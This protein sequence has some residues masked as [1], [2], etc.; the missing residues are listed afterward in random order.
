MA[1]ARK[2][3]EYQ[4]KQR[5][6]KCRNAPD[7]LR[8]AAGGVITAEVAAHTLHILAGQGISGP[9]SRGRSDWDAVLAGVVPA[10]TKMSVRQFTKAVLAA[11]KLGLDASWYIFLFNQYVVASSWDHSIE[12][13]RAQLVAFSKDTDDWATKTR[14]ARAWMAS[15]DPDY[16]LYHLTAPE[17]W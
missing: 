10:A 12:A 2:K 16:P 7:I 9:P 15:Q 6:N 13:Y 5:L 8:V 11:A 14:T 4:L 1:A 17:G 3:A